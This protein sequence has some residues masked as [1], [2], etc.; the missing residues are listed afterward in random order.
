[1]KG[2]HFLTAPARFFVVTWGSLIWLVPEG[3]GWNAPVCDS[4]V[5]VSS[6]Q[7]P[8]LLSFTGVQR[9]LPLAS[10]LGRPVVWTQTGARKSRPLGSR[11]HSLCSLPC[12]RRSVPVL[13]EAEGAETARSLLGLPTGL[14]EGTPEGRWLFALS[15]PHSVLTASC[16]S[17]WGTFSV[18][19]ARA[20]PLQW[21]ST[22]AARYSRSE[23]RYAEAPA[24]DLG[25][26]GH[27]GFA[28]LP[29]VLAHRQGE[30]PHS[31]GSHRGLAC[32]ASSALLHR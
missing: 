25:R 6:D 8:V 1:M 10:R 11:L 3:L 22:L 4:L 26:G 19:K 13:C 9:C 18:C 29:G 28:S 30:S 23:G 17:V 27:R 15:S 5:P 14:G 20:L 31:P 21:L 2:P 32:G 7:A 16:E 12:H 24:Q